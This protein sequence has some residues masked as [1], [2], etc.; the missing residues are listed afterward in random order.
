VNAIRVDSADDP[1][2]AVATF[3]SQLFG[4]AR[5][6]AVL[7]TA[8]KAAFEVLVLERDGAVCNLRTS[9]S[10]T[11]MPNSYDVQLDFDVQRKQQASEPLDLELSAMNAFIYDV[12]RWTI[13]DDFIPVLES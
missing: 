7:P 4:L 6:G 13:T 11:G 8:F 10:A 2:Q 5:S 12:F 1:A 3:N 9:L